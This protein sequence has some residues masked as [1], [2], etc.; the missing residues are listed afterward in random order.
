M[1][2]SNGS[3]SPK[4][5]RRRSTRLPGM[6]NRPIANPAI[7]EITS[8]TGTTA[9]TMSTLENRSALMFA[10]LNASRKLPHWGS[11]GQDRPTGALP[12]G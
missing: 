7:V 1:I 2:P 8:D 3:V 9:R 6:R 10:T 12:D 5:N 4:M 11:A